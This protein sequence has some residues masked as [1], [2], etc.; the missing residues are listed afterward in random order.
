[1]G[2]QTAVTSSNAVAQVDEV[3]QAAGSKAADLTPT[4]SYK[5]LY[6]QTESV[7]CTSV[8]WQLIDA[9]RLLT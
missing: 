9:N 6:V 5:A 8:L 7:C 1:M 3:L 4:I 2:M